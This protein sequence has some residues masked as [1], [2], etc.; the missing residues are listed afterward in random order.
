MKATSAGPEPARPVESGSVPVAGG[1]LYYERVG[2]GPVLAFAHGLGG[3]YRSWWQQIPILSRR[4]SCVTF[5]HRGFLPSRDDQASHPVPELFARDFAT[6]LDHLEIDRLAIVAQSMGGWTAMEFALRAPE[7]VTALVLAGTTGT[8]RQTGILSL[9]ET[10]AD[11]RVEA[12]RARGIHP[13]AG[14]RLAHEQPDL[15]RRFV[16][17]DK[18]SGTFDRGP[19]RAALDRMRV[20]EAEELLALRC[21]ILAVVGDEDL[22]CPPGNVEIM[23][24]GP[25]AITRVVITRSGH[26][27]YFERAAVFNQ[28]VQ[29]FLEQAR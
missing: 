18:A 21:P 4:Y 8:L 5:S 12:L 19:V 27:A 14:E 2:R 10:G 1:S 28:T 15:Y 13:A 20:R 3:N 22:V 23:A 26:S 16:E 7:R 6:L 9:A 17:I 29:R 24:E 25:V 11:P